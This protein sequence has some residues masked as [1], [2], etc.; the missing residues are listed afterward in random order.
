[1]QIHSRLST[2]DAQAVVCEW[3][4]SLPWHVMKG[5]G[6]GDFRVDHCSDRTRSVSGYILKPDTPIKNVPKIEKAGGGHKME[7]PL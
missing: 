5:N 3:S 4:R 2:A 1:M 6:Q 7:I